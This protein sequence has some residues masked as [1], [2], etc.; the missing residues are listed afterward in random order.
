MK[1]HFFG[2]T[3]VDQ[4]SWLLW[5]TY[6]QSFLKIRSMVQQLSRDTSRQ[7]ICKIV[8]LKLG[9]QFVQSIIA[10]ISTRSTVHTEL[11]SIATFTYFLSVHLS[12]ESVSWSRMCLHS[13][14]CL[15][16]DVNWR[17][18]LFVQLVDRKSYKL[19]L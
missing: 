7:T 15:H 3:Q 13:S 11:F 5:L 17:W 19:S 6:L 4:Q 1:T 18:C 16:C 12:L 9:P 14:C 2:S 10:C 8:G